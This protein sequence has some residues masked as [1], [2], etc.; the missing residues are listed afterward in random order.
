[1]KWSIILL[2][3]IL[4]LIFLVFDYFFLFWLFLAFTIILIFVKVTVATA[5]G[6]VKVG[7]ELTTNI[8][9]DAEE[10]QPE[11]ISGKVLTEVSE[12]FGKKTAEGVWSDNRH[13]WTSDNLMARIGQGAKNIVNMFFKIF[14]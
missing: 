9:K 10:A 8:G 1:M 2:V 6:T 5:K 12:E 4:A 7:K 13:R 11:P 3:L 14:K